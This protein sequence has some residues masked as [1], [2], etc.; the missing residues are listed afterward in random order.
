MTLP[1]SK[2]SFAVTTHNEGEYIQRLLDQLIP[3]CKETGDEIVILDDYSDDEVTKNILF[4]ALETAGQENSGWNLKLGF[5]RLNSDFA[6]QK[7]RLNSMCKGE[8][9]FQIDADETF[10]PGLL[11][12][13]HDIVEANETIDLFAIPRVN[14]V[15]GL[16]EEDI[17]RWGWRI[18]KLESQTDEKVLD[19]DSDE[20]KML[21]KHGLIIEET[22][23]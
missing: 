17:R 21:K 2:I 14:T 11:M 15:E 20:Y 1:K 19:T 16:T 6:N 12:Y 22:K 8:Y 13:L 7:N 5:Q 3:H 4:N 10:H 18:S 9:I 23:K